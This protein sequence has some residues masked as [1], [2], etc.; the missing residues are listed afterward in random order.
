M[1]NLQDT[2]NIF[3]QISEQEHSGP[4]FLSMPAQLCYV[5]EAFTLATGKLNW[6]TEH[7]QELILTHQRKIPMAKNTF[8]NQ[9]SMVTFALTDFASSLYLFS[10]LSKE[11]QIILLRHNIPLY[12]QYI[13]AR[14]FSSE[15]GFEQLS[16]I[17]E[18]QILIES[19]EE[20]T[21]LHRIS[22]KRYNG[23]TNLLPT[24]ANHYSHFSDNIGMFYPFPQQCNGL[25]ANMLL[26]YKDDAMTKQLKEPARI[27]CIFEEAKEL[28]KFGFRHLD[29]NVGVNIPC[30]IG[31]LIQTLT[32]MKNIFDSCKVKTDGLIQSGC[33]T[34]TIPLNLV[35]NEESWLKVQYNTFQAQFMSVQMTQNDLDSLMNVD[36]SSRQ[37]QKKFSKMWMSMTT[38]RI[39]RVLK[40]RPEF[41]NLTLL[42]QKYLWSRNCR[43][44]VA[45]V[46]AQMNCKKT[47][48]IHLKSMLGCFE[49]SPLEWESPSGTDVNLNQMT[50]AV[51]ASFPTEIGSKMSSDFK[52]VR[53]FNVMREMS[54]FVDQFFMFF[55]LLTLLNTSGLPQSHCYSSLTQVRHLYLQVFQRKL[56]TSGCSFIKYAQMQ[57]TFQK[58]NKLSDLETIL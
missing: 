55:I 56:K 25:I 54:V 36:Q 11:D 19:I 21:K 33:F 49:P 13:I 47:A 22:L 12:L 29:R 34:N 23:F 26:Y 32:K 24:S 15:T 1:N 48:Q 10:S 52:I 4:D 50:P 9:L 7:N 8:T 6:S 51:L 18:G 16:W 31:P 35:E 20:V 38:E 3:I 5:L 42:Q 41:E 17:L 53:L 46:I 28:V 14:Y 40:I 58:L 37:F 45:A 57:E 2:K 27:A 43:L 30:N 39:W 44:A